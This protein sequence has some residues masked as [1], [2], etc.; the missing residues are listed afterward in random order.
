MT[1]AHVPDGISFATKPALALTMIERAL[2]AGVPFAWVAADSV[3]GVGDIEM[4]L[5]RAGKAY[6]LGVTPNHHFG[7]W[8]GKPPMAG[9]ALEIAQGLAPSAWRRLSAG[10]G[11]K[12]ARL[13]DWAY[14]DWPISTP[15][16]GSEQF[17]P[18]DARSS[19]PPPYL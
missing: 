1:A 5:R 17:R 18:L 13:H 6:V 9:T 4:A 3:Y 15:P 10:E 16:I 14:C 2:A 7:S 11:T 8:S 12:G 19:D